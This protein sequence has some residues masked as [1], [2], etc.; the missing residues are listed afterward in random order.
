MGEKGGREERECGR[1]GKR[2]E[3]REGGIEVRERKRK[4]GRK[5]TREGRI[6]KSWE[7][8]QEKNQACVHMHVQ[9]K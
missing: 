7:R 1:K 8:E 3:G 9:S 4:Q 6:N 5:G 2:D